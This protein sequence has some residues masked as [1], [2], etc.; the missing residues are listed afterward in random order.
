MRPENALP[1]SNQ[2][3]YTERKKIICMQQCTDK[4]TTSV[5][6]PAILI[7]KLLLSIWKLPKIWNAE[8]SKEFSSKSL[9]YFGYLH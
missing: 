9:H 7:A 1:Y 6:Q 8:F 3:L 2:A 5:S 4:P